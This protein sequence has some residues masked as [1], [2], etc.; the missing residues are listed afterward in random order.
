MTELGNASR[1]RKALSVW[2]ELRAEEE[3]S[4]RSR[5][6]ILLAQKRLVRQKETDRPLGLSTAVKA[7]KRKL[8]EV[9][10]Q[11]CFDLSNHVLN[12]VLRICRR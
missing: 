7:K 6:Q 2:E 4:V 11:F 8:D 10:V 5:M 9:C 12:V 3:A 1:K